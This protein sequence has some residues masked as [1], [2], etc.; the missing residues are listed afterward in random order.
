MPRWIKYDPSAQR[1]YIHDCSQCVFLGTYDYDAPWGD[2][3]RHLVADLY[4]CNPPPPTPEEEWDRTSLLARF[5]DEAHEYASGS[6]N[7]IERNL[8]A[9]AYREGLSTYCAPLIEA[10]RRWYPNRALLLEEEAC[11]LL[12]IKEDQ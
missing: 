2:G 1:T 7:G 5:G 12:G 6:P 11:R 10:W 4:A 9:G 3:T 8:L